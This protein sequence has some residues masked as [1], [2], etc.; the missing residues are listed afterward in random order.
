MKAF[1]FIIKPAL[2]LHLLKSISFHYL[3]GSYGCFDPVQENRFFRCT[4]VIMFDQVMGMIGNQNF[5][6]FCRTMQSGRKI[7]ISSYNGISHAVISP[8]IAYVTIT[9]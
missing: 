5:I 4:Q 8:I 3:P 6:Y 2:I 1:I 9:G 7:G